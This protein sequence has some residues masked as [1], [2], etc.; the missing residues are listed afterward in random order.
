M[1]KEKIISRLKKAVLIAIVRADDSAALPEAIDALVA[2]GIGA[3]ELT[4]T[5][6]N[7]PALLRAES[8]K[9]GNS[10]LLGM[11]SIL[12]EE[13][14]LHAIDSGAHFIVT[15]VFRPTVIAACA[16]KGIP[17]ASGAFTPTE[18]VQA[19]EAGADFVKLFPAENL[20]ASY[21]KSIRGPLPQLQIIPTGG[22]NLKTI[23][24]FLAAGCPALGIGSNLVSAEILKKKDWAALK[25]AA[26]A[27]VAA[28]TAARA[29]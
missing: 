12:H 9:R 18:A 14:A 22:V 2:G 6:P 7:A 15:P 11:G 26:A 19:W 8:A 3:V 29:R 20:G 27:H 17:I 10:L 28:V 5:T 24:E 16:R 1:K 21:V 4:L 23:P 25:A 13:D